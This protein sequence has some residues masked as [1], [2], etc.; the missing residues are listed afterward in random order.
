V[1]GNKYLAQIYQEQ[2]PCL[3]NPQIAFCDGLTGS[4]DKQQRHAVFLA[5]VRSLIGFPTASP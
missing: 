1:V 4:V 2:M 3:T 5:S